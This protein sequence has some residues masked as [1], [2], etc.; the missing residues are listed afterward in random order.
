SLGTDGFGRSDTRPALRR[1]YEVDA[2]HVVVATLAALAE[3]GEVKPEQVAEAID[4]YEIDPERGAPFHP[5]A[6]TS[7]A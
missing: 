1:F 2:E 3:M 6:G 5:D 4:R 7:L